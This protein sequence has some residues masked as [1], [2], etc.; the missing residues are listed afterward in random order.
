MESIGFRFTIVTPSRSNVLSSDYSYATVTA[1]TVTDDT[2]TGLRTIRNIST[3]GYRD[4]AQNAFADLTMSACLYEDGGLGSY[5]VEYRDAGTVD[6]YRAKAMASTL[7]RAANALQKEADTNGWPA[8]LGQYVAIMARAL[9]VTTIVVDRPGGA[10]D[11]CHSYDDMAFDF[12]PLNTGMAAID[13]AIVA[14]NAT[15]A[16]VA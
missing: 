10:N 1:V 16:A 5:H 4:D 3:I 13:A 11:R 15:R 6:L 2:P 7:T 9:K 8:T 14:H 12:L